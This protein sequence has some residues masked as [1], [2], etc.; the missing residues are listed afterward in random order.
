MGSDHSDTQPAP[1]I[2]ASR[3][4]WEQNSSL[5]GYRG[6]AIRGVIH[7]ERTAWDSIDREGHRGFMGKGVELR[8]AERSAK[9]ESRVA[10]QALQ[11]RWGFMEY[12]GEFPIGLCTLIPRWPWEPDVIILRVRIAF[13][14]KYTAT[15]CKD[16][17]SPSLSPLSSF[18]SCL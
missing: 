15:G 12:G 9:D 5:F 14:W 7:A 6:K 11:L 18:S 16:L 13:L 1:G 10:N 3:K 8:V 4:Q 17:Y 2:E